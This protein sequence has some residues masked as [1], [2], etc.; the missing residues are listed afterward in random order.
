MK[1]KT[2]ARIQRVL[3]ASPGGGF[4]NY[5]LQRVAGRSYRT[6]DDQFLFRA[7]LALRQLELCAPYLT[8]DLASLKAYEFGA[9]SDLV[10]PLSR[11]A[12]GLRHQVVVDLEVLIRA[13]LVAEAVA[14]LNRHAEA[15]G[16]AP[17]PPLDTRSRA[18]AIAGLER[19]LGITYRAPFD[20]TATDLP[21]ATFDLVFSNSTLEHI[22]RD[23]IG[24]LLGDCRR[25]LKDD[26]VMCFRIDYEDH[27]AI[28]DPDL[29]PYNFLRYGEKE[30]A[31]FNSRIHYQNR[32]RHRD[33]CELFE[34]HGL[35]I[36][37]V[38]TIEPAPDAVRE[39]AAIAVAGEFR[40]YTLEELGI[41]KGV[42]VLRKTRMG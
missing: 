10:I 8:G 27:F 25:V 18:R 15:L 41:R 26:G 11:A 34:A 3:S 16:I 28:V 36:V 4:L 9:G 37:H 23:D 19:T 13:G 33:Y 20:A 32:L 31:R 2:K 17:L 42:F 21:A 29:S 7:R 38:E 30:W 5:L 40:R 14:R 22:P 6:G 1:W 35:D 39:L 24:P 12:R